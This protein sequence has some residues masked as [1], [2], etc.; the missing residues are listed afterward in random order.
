MNDPIKNEKTLETIKI[1][2]ES[3]VLS[4]QYK[5]KRIKEIVG[6]TNIKTYKSKIT[7]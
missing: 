1:I 3:S 6:T 7:F 2:I 4:D 5:L